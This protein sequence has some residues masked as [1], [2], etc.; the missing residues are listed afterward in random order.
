[1]SAPPIPDGALPGLG[2]LGRLARDPLGFMES[3]RPLG[4]VVLIRL[5][6]TPYYVIND[7]SLIRQ[8]L[9]TDAVRMRKGVQYEKLRPLLGNAVAMTA[10]REH[11]D[12]R[13]RLQPVF[14]PDRIRGY[15]ALMHQAAV[16]TV[17]TW[18]PGGTVDVVAEM[19]RLA[20]VVVSRALCSAELSDEAS[21]TI[22]R[23]LPAV[24]SGITWRSLFPGGLLEQLP[25]PMNRRFTQANQRLLTTIEGLVAAQQDYGTDG[26][27]LLSRLL[28]AEGGR[29]GAMPDTAAVRDEAVNL[30]FAGTETTGSALAWLWY[31]VSEHPKIEERLAEHACDGDLSYAERV[32]RETL[33]LYPPAWLISRRSTE[34]VRL[35]AYEIPMG[36]SILFSPYSLHREPSVFPDATSFDPDRW[37]PDREREIPRGAY[38]PFGAG[39]HNCIGERF[40]LLEMSIVA[41]TIAARYRLVP[42][43]PVRKRARA[44]LAPAGPGMRLSPR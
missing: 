28:R 2:H 38:L 24:L 30:L 8:V 6:R 33:R 26:G 23:D 17:D 18:A 35:G 31:A 43:G 40:A 15:S 37:L 10:G 27:D 32:A 20:L 22:Q 5:G 12:R 7:P 19:H 42:T 34:P 13:R 44:T 29:L 4:Q 11:R 21:A 25:L 16:E 3:V 14:H 1:M 39:P 41:S 9:V 36:A